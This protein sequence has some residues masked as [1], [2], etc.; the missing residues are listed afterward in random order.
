MLNVSHTNNTDL[1]ALSMNI[2]GEIIKYTLTALG[3]FGNGLILAAT[4]WPKIGLKQKSNI[5]IG[6]LALCDLLTNIA[7]VMV[8]SR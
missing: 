2:I 8:L 7:N 4:M 1:Q 5:L 6:E 3:L